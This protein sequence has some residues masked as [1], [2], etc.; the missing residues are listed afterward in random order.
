MDALLHARSRLPIA[1]SIANDDTP[2]KLVIKSAA[3]IF[4]YYMNDLIQE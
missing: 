4:I 3:I 2:N 1:S